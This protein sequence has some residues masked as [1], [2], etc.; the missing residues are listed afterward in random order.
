M[1]NLRILFAYCSDDPWIAVV[2]EDLNHV[3][4]KLGHELYVAAAGNS[5]GIDKQCYINTD[6]FN[7]NY[8]L[9]KVFESLHY[10]SIDLTWLSHVEYRLV[11]QQIGGEKIAQDA[12]LKKMHL[13]LA[14]AVIIL[15]IIQ[16]DAVIIWNGLL[17]KRAVY[18]KAA[19]Y[20][21]IP[22]YYAEKGMLP[23]SWYI[24]SKGINGMSSVAERE[25]GLDFSRKSIN[26][27]RKFVDIIDKNGASAWE[28]PSRRELTGLK[29]DLKIKPNQQVIFFPGQVDSD[30]N[31]V[32]F[33]EHFRNTL[34]ALNWLVNSL[35]K[36]DF[37][38]LVKPHPKGMVKKEDLENIV[39][40]K[41][42]V[43]P[44]IN[45]L[46]AIA[47]A[48]CVVSINST[49]CFEAAIRG[50]PVL[51][52]GQ[53]IL[54]DKDYVA[55]YKPTVD[56]YAQVSACIASYN[57]N[58]DDLYQKALSFADYLDSEY[59]SYRGDCEKTMR[60]LENILCTSGIR[61]EKYFTQQEIFAL[62]QDVSREDFERSLS[63]GISYKDIN[64][65]FPGRIVVK[66]LLEKVKSRCL[67]LS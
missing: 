66:A 3:S 24:D 11:N 40:D 25:I 63:M 5:Y 54:F 49:I 53:G 2:A 44:E 48:D 33:S 27:L 13:W 29:Q 16:P 60:M 28:Q 61:K 19:Q 32:L 52:L 56:A 9:C 23:N 26:S 15:K 38:I 36:D 31:I 39:G 17:S 30:S 34:D 12:V 45:V 22:V 8:Y 64:R 6:A 58:K 35:T 51:L 14:E 1:N 7:S 43:L 59:Y 47:L 67:G 50:K 65:L 21:K 37:F 10:N 57:Q 4:K 20:F 62:L 42:M 41:G 55:I 46:D 18:L